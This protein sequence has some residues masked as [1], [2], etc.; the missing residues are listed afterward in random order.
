MSEVHNYKLS[1]EEFLIV[2]KENSWLYGP[3]ARAIQQKYGISFSRQAVRERAL[4]FPDSDKEM[5]EEVIDLAEDALISTIKQNDNPALRLK[6]AIY[7]LNNTGKGRGYGAIPKPS[8]E[9]PEQVFE[10]AGKEFRF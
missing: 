3:T 10:I 2:L 8:T 9:N 5:R 4:K 7:V 1:D 6:A